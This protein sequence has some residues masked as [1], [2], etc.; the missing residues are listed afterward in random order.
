[1]CLCILPTGRF[2]AEIFFEIITIWIGSWVGNCKHHRGTAMQTK[3]Q[4][5]RC[6]FSFSIIYESFANVACHHSFHHFLCG[7]CWIPK[8]F[9]YLTIATLGILLGGFPYMQPRTAF[10]NFIESFHLSYTRHN[11]D[12][13]IPTLTHS[14]SCNVA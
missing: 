9:T 3:R 6:N 8:P 1:M 2:V 14:A 7:S 12:S 5:S 13:C 11:T 4:K 10:E